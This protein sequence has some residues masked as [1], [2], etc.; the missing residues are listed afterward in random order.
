MHACVVCFVFEWVC[1]YLYDGWAGGQKDRACQWDKHKLNLWSPC[2]FLLRE[3]G[4]ESEGTCMW[5]P[6]S[7]VC[8]LTCDLTAA[9]MS[10]LLLHVV[11]VVSLCK[12]CTEGRLFLPLMSTSILSSPLELCTFRKKRCLLILFCETSTQLQSIKRVRN[13]AC[14]IRPDNQSINSLKSVR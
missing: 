1:V 4:R 13:D 6:F 2:S 14:K 11:S 9:E 12:W 5:S 10:S 7:V 3:R 8:L